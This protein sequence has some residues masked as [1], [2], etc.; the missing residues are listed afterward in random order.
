MID[1]KKGN[2][3]ELPT[4]LLMMFIVVTFLVALLPGMVQMINTAQGSQYLNCAGYT[5]D[6]PAN[7]YNASIPTS[8]IGCLAIKLYVPYIVLGV[9]VAVVAGVFYGKTGMGGGGASMGGGYYG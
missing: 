9:L 6:T 8:T 2:I 1:S 4:T 5:Y 3:Y 7:N